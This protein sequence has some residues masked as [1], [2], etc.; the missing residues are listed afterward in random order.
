MVYRIV[1]CLITT[2]C[3]GYSIVT[4]GRPGGSKQQIICLMHM[5]SVEEQVAHLRQQIEALNERVTVM[6]SHKEGE[7]PVD[8]QHGSEISEVGVNRHPKLHGNA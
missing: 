7:L 3:L 2:N 8:E 6:A 1:S 4:K 5:T